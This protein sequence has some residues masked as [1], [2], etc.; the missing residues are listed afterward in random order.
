MTDNNE[1][2]QKIAIMVDFYSDRAEAH[3]TLFLAFLFGLFTILTI[4]GNENTYKWIWTIPYWL[5]FLGGV[6]TFLNFSYYATHAQKITE[7]IS[8]YEVPEVKKVL[9]KVKRSLNLAWFHFYK[10]RIGK[11]V[12]LSSIVAY[13]I[14][15][16]LSCWLVIGWIAATLGGLVVSIAI[17]VVYFRAEEMKEKELKEE[18]KKRKT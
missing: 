10:Q 14:I 17:V 9:D 1:K 13:F 16:F 6:H 12:I 18:Q 4:A 2:I 11:W 8:C 15:A 7:E 5:L 3:A